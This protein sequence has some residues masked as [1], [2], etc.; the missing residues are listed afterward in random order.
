MVL[1]GGNSRGNRPP[2]K[3]ST[4]WHPRQMFLDG[5]NQGRNIGKVQP[6]PA[7]CA[8]FPPVGVGVNGQKVHRNDDRHEWD[9]YGR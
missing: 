6:G 8:R 5:D 2:P 1:C 3:K 9:Y 7:T 4:P